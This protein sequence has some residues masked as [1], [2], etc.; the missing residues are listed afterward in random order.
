M[1]L[2]A[3]GEALVLVQRQGKGPYFTLT[4][5]STARIP[6]LVTGEAFAIKVLEDTAV[7]DVARH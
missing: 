4:W 7:L 5:C 2:A 6:A 3:V 1:P